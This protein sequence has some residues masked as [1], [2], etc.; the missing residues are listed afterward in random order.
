MSTENPSDTQPAAPPSISETSTSTS[1]LGLKLVSDVATSSKCPALKETSSALTPAKKKK[2][3]EHE[4]DRSVPKKT[5]HKSHGIGPPSVKNINP[6]P[7]GMESISIEW[8]TT[9]IPDQ[10]F[11]IRQDGSRDHTL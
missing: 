2:K 9:I 8:K 5:T 3:K 6:D 10:G 7:L 4:M 11:L 1:P